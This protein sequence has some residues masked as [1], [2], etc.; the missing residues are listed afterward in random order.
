MVS[1][2]RM[3]TSWDY[4]VEVDE[5]RVLFTPPPPAPTEVLRPEDAFELSTKLAKAAK[6]ATQ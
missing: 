6:D 3:V 1:I 5:G 4:G 2:A